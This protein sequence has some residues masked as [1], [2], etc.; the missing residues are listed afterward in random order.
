MPGSVTLVTKSTNPT[1]EMIDDALLKPAS[2]SLSIMDDI[3]EHHG[4]EELQHSRIRV[5][6]ARDH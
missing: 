4:P 6:Y 5:V 3:Q 1:S 2:S